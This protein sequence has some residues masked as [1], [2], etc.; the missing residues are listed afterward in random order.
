[1]IE[2]TNLSKNYGKVEA[3]RDV[4]FAVRPGEIYGLLGPN[5]A[6]KSTTIHVLSGLI[7]ASAGT[8]KVG[9]HDIARE[10][11]AAKRILGVVP[12]QSIVIE[13]LSALANCMF[14]GSLYGVDRKALRERA[15][16]LLDWIELSD[17]L[18]KPASALS[19]GMLRR[20]TLVL[21]IIHE[22]KALILDEPTTGLDPQTRLLILD[23][24]R[25]VASK[26]T[27]VLLTTHHLEEAERLCHR[28]GIIDGG[29]IIKEGTLAQLRAEVEDVQLFSLRGDFERET[30]REAVKSLPGA[31]IVLDDASEVVVAVPTGSGLTARLIETAA[32]LDL[33]QEVAI[34]PPS[35]ESLFIRLTGRELRE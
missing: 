14:F 2:V 15:R 7:A 25:E 18:N 20:L 19:G 22:P 3:V 31:E 29:R 26:G 17:H 34:K 28:V 4:S 35:L 11:L 10:P 13:E 32:S 6:G 27:A 9:G 23:R 1:M 24:V 30:L 33:V 8:A 16:G 12:Q 21:G 5:G